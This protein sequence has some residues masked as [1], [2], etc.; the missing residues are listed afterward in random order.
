MRRRRFLELATVGSAALAGCARGIW[1]TP[2]ASP[3]GTPKAPVFEHFVE[4]SGR[5]FTVDTQPF[6]TNG[7]N[8]QYLYDLPRPWVDE[9]F[10]DAASMGLTSLRI[11]C[12][13][14]H[15]GVDPSLQ[16]A[17]YE[18]SELAFQALDYVIDQAG[19]HGI[20]VILVLTD[21]WS[22]GG[23]Q[24]YVDWS[25]SAEARS[26]FYTDDECRSMF[27]AFIDYLLQRENTRTGVQYRNDPTIMLWEL[28]NEPQ[29]RSN[30]D[31]D[32]LESDLEERERTL[33]NWIESAS[34]YLKSQD[35]NH[36]V[37]TG[38]EGYYNEQKP[39]MGGT[40][41][42]TKLAQDYIENHQP[43]TI[44]ACSV[45]LYPQSITHEDRCV[46]E[47]NCVDTLEFHVVDGHEQ[48][49]KPVYLGEFGF[50]VDRLADDVD[51]QLQERNELL[52]R[53]Y[54]ALARLEAD[55]ALLWTL[56]PHQKEVGD[57]GHGTYFIVFE[58]DEGTSE[59]VSEYSAAVNDR[60]GAAAEP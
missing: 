14:G 43:E 59:V 35:S 5:H 32:P 51:Q 60:S 30:A 29:L 22:P 15:D 31:G 13:I 56:Y 19:R 6:Y 41:W 38:I 54:D 49:E 46:P 33:Q 55:G 1:S 12:A 3:T 57:G 40:E 44:D 37:S 48:L 26:D 34:S 52:A 50:P 28:M 8:N 4:R 18:Y 42:Y 53:W 10:A 9:L 45:H 16:V 11:E 23:I 20:R 21:Y 2:T 27:R 7:A 17:P 47:E 25:D 39:W 58:E 24:A 36:L